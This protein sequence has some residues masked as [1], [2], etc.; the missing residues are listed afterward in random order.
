[1]ATQI[2]MLRLIDELLE[3]FGADDALVAIE[4]SIENDRNVVTIRYLESDA[5]F[6][7][8][9]R[10]LNHSGV[11]SLQRLD[12][13]SLSLSSTIFSIRMRNKKLSC[14]AT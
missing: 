10:W 8:P 11:L 3:M 14:Y 7:K 13:R 6:T 9:T 5:D 2:E 1:M 4:E 12:T